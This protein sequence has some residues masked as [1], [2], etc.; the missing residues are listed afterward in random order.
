M[1]MMTKVQ[2]LWRDVERAR[3]VA[4]IKA[5]MDDKDVFKRAVIFDSVKDAEERFSRE[6]LFV[7]ED[8]MAYCHE[9]EKLAY[10]ADEKIAALH[11][12]LNAL[13]EV[14]TNPRKPRAKKAK[15]KEK[16][17]VK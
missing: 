13:K 10:E 8:L 11:H 9:M 14:P 2:L 17:N 15:K 5:D 12:E 3:R 16:T 4:H 1:Y 7:F 6:L